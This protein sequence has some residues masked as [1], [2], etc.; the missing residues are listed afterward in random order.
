MSAVSGL[1]HIGIH[2]SDLARARD[3]YSRVVGLQVTA[4][5]EQLGGM[6]FLSAQPEREHHEV[7]L[8]A[9]R[10]AGPEVQLLN[11]IS[12]RV[13][14]LDGL[15]ELSGRFRQAGATIEQVVTHGH[16][17]SLYAFDPDGNRLE[18]YYKTGEIQPYPFT[19]S[20]DLGQPDE[21]L[22]SKVHKVT[23]E[24]RRSEASARE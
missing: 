23:E 12:L 17:V 6:V 14:S 7:V 3:F 4:E 19:E 9:G 10:R 2:V 24:R 18:F 5:S 1:G 13:G 21:A 16:S 8:I 15:R 11:Q 20:V 22:L